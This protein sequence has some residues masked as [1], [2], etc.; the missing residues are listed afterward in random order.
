MNVVIY[1][2]PIMLERD[3]KKQAT[4][5]LNSLK[6]NDAPATEIAVEHHDTFNLVLPHST[7]PKCG[8]LITAE[9][10]IPILSYIFLKGKCSQCKEG[11]SVR[12]PL[13]ELFTG[14]ISAYLAW[15]FG[16]SWQLL[17]VLVFSY[18]LI[19]QAMIDWDTQYLLD[20]ITFP[21]LW[22]GLLINSY[23][24]FTSLN[25]ALWG[26]V[27]GYLSLWSV[28]WTYKL[29]TGKEGMGYGDFKLLAMLGAWMGWQMIP[30][31]ILISSVS[32]S[33]IVG[34]LLILNKNRDSQQPVSFGPYLA[35]AG[36]IALIWGEQLVNSYLQLLQF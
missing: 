35:L 32:G 17:A 30:L 36:W 11:I 3:F 29:M 33:L 25:D 20:D 13:V 28:Y 31:I 19:C 6:N 4:E 15:H 8:H 16:F 26:A 5:Y 2:L 14:L 22:L 34:T 7:C 9:E 23:G 24:L 12:Y 1:R 18:A 27:V 10:N 21:L